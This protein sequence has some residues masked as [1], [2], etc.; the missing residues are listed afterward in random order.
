MAFPL[1]LHIVIFETAHHR[2]GTVAKW[3]VA[4][5]FLQVDVLMMV[6]VIVGIVLRIHFLYRFF[7]FNQMLNTFNIWL[8]LVDIWGVKVYSH[9]KREITTK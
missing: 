5:L 4:S 6:N 7:L 8:N 1:S 2:T 9:F 3:F